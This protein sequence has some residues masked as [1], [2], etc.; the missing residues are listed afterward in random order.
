MTSAAA[1][2]A[3]VAVSG[4][5]M[6]AM[7]SD[8]TADTVQSSRPFF[9]KD[10]TDEERAQM[11][12]NREA[13]QAEMDAKQAAIN[14]ALENSDYQAWVEAV[15]ENCPMLDKINEGNFSRLVEANQYMGKAKA[16]FEELGVKGGGFGE[17]GGMRGP[18]G[19]NQ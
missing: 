14:S 3:L 16:I 6:S 2:V 17:R 10:L 18:R 5:A 13:R 15:G 7:A 12:V 8:D 9:G 19:I 1:L 11:E 4:I